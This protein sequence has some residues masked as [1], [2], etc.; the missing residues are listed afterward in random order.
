M[1]TA[2]TKH[3]SAKAIIAAQRAAKKAKRDERI[4]LLLWRVK[5]N[6]LFL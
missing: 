6:W 4:L 3:T 5:W 2:T 1:Q